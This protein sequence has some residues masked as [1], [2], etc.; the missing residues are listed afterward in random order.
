MSP[1]QPTWRHKAQ[2]GL[3]GTS[4]TDKV[5]GLWREG[6]GTVWAFD[7]GAIADISGLFYVFILQPHLDQHRALCDRNGGQPDPVSGVGSPGEA[8]ASLISSRA[9]TTPGPAALAISPGD[10][11]HRGP[12]EERPPRPPGEIRPP[13]NAFDL[14]QHP[15]KST[16][17]RLIF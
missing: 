5:S 13:P 12:L 7:Y 11:D 17:S 6:R 2:K 8:I 10:D 1:L 14:L 3:S 9:S 15:Q 4:P 16:V